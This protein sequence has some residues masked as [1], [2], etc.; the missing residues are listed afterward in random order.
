MMISQK[1]VLVHTSTLGFSLTPCYLSLYLFP[2]NVSWQDRTPEELE[3]GICIVIQ[4]NQFCYKEAQLSFPFS[5]VINFILFCLD[6]LN[7][8]FHTCVEL[9]A[10]E[11]HQSTVTNILINA[12]DSLHECCLCVAFISLQ[13]GRLTFLPGNQTVD[14]PSINFMKRHGTVF[15]NAYTNSP[16]CCPS[17]AG[18]TK[19]NIR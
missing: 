9:A 12:A 7:T 8:V 5:K 11:Q 15:L 13:D 18:R 17:R 4:W 2:L 6:F 10:F 19:Q 14:L 1:Y 3:L 16:I